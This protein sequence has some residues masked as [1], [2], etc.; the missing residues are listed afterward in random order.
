M[1][2]ASTLSI[3]TLGITTLSS[4]K[5]LSIEDTQR[6]SASRVIVLSYVFMIMP[7]VV[8]LNVIMLSFVMLNVIMQSAVM[9][10]FI[11]LNVIMLSFVM[12]NGIMLSSVVL[13]VIRYTE[14]CYAECH[15]SLC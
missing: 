10:S 6:H 5:K 4:N 1:G 12:L 3:M 9:L 11:V 7:R 14:C 2:G 15:Y 8:I 13:N